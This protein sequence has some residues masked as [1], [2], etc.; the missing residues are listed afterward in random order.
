MMQNSNHHELLSCLWSAG[1]KSH[2]FRQQTGIRPCKGSNQLE[3]AEKSVLK[4]LGLNP[5]PI[6]VLWQSQAAT[7]E[8][9]ETC[10]RIGDL[11]MWQA[12]PQGEW[13]RHRGD[14]QWGTAPLWARE[15]LSRTG[16]AAPVVTSTAVARGQA[17][18]LGLW[19]GLSW[20]S[21]WVLV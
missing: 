4:W 12:A 21:D 5:S 15:T 16:V 9:E 2:V 3:Q 14:L 7:G 13:N 19:G 11:E 17:R 18:Q 8:S 1:T 10:S 6:W 20:E